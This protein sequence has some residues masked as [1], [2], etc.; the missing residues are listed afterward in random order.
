MHPPPDRL[1]RECTPKIVRPI[2][3]PPPVKCNSNLSKTAHRTNNCC[4][5]RNI[6]L[7]FNTQILF[8]TSNILWSQPGPSAVH[9]LPFVTYVSNGSVFSEVNT[10]SKSAATDYVQT[11]IHSSNLSLLSIFVKLLFIYFLI[12]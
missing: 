12:M 7:T 2:Y 4:V 3:P 9:V 8:E 1:Y 11:K 6:H 10:R 5:A